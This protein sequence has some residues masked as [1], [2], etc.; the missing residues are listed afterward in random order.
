[1][2]VR[3]AG[4]ALVLLVWAPALVEADE[5][6]QVEIDKLVLEEGVEGFRGYYTRDARWLALGGRLRVVPQVTWGQWRLRL[7]A[8]AEH[9]TPIASLEGQGLPQVQGEGSASLRYR[10]S[11]RFRVTLEGN[12]GGRDRSNWPDQ[13]QPN[14]SGDLLLTDRYSGWWRGFGLRIAA[15]PLR[16]HHLRADYYY[17]LVEYRHDPNYDAIER[18]THL[19]P[20]SNQEHGGELAWH[21]LDDGL[22]LGGGLSWF[23]RQY[24]YA[25]A[26]DAGTGL[27]HASAGGP[28]PNPLERLWGIDPSVDVEVDLADGAVTL[29]VEY[30]HH[31]VLDPF[32]GYRSLQGPYVKGRLEVR[33]HD[34][35]EIRV[36]L[37]Y[38]HYLYFQGGYAQ[39]PNHPPLDGGQQR[40]DQRCK[41][42]LEIDR[43][44]GPHLHLVFELQFLWRQTN[45]PDYQPGIFPASR[46][47][48]VDWDYTNY[49]T[50]LGL[51][52]AL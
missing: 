23:Y 28:P 46:S 42:R 3:A 2:H 51:R 41:G 38:R 11:G 45:F 10:P 24:F 1:V 21:F 35:L 36:H 25:F 16:H 48:D 26:R 30:R 20:R 52:Y 13:Y 5:G 32:Q 18:P 19:V 49:R 31:V 17:D 29:D 15:I 27:T 14:P 7:D 9:S 8:D 47:Y 40:Y 50:M 6:P 33:P 43:R 12:I 22:R 34:D 37:T 44:L 4:L 39:S